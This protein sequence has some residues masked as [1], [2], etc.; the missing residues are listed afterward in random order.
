[1]EVAPHKGM[2]GLH[3]FWLRVEWDGCDKSI[4]QSALTIK[5]PTVLNMYL[6]FV[7]THYLGKGY[8][9]EFLK[10]NLPWRGE[11]SHAIKVF[12]RKK[13]FKNNLESL[14]DCLNAFCT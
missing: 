7:Y 3:I 9:N 5:T 6:E 4:Y 11:A 8:K 12:W 10:W 14:P 2:Q 1:M 13:L